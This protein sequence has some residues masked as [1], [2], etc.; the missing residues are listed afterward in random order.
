MVT[1]FS[2]HNT[3]DDWEE[4]Y[5]AAKEANHP[6]K[7]RRA[8]AAARAFIAGKRDAGGALVPLPRSGVLVLV[9]PRPVLPFTKTATGRSRTSAARAAG[10]VAAL[11]I[12]AAAGGMVGWFF[13]GNGDP[14]SPQVGSPP[15]FSP[16]N[17]A[18][19]T[20]Q[21]CSRYE[22]TA[23][24]L[25]LRD[26]HNEFTGVF[27]YRTEKVTVENRNT[28]DGVKP[29]WWVTTDPSP[30]REVRSGWVR[31]DPAFWKMACPTN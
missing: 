15:A 11:I 3:R 9:V 7:R 31:P 25:G 26:L 22:I 19:P 12:A 16:T 27:I 6:V 4:L 1:F 29:M 5:K 28:P 20:P 8:F 10:Y 13:N 2:L 23:K 18:S 30:T 14:S 17:A 24:T 21:R